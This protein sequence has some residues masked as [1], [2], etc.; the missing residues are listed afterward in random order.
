MTKIYEV[1]ATAICDV[2]IRIEA[3]SEDEA[4]KKVKADEGEVVDITFVRFDTRRSMFAK[5]VDDVVA[6]EDQ[7]D[8]R[9][10]WESVASVT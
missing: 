10:I 7:I 3:L 2:T 4:I 5:F 6:A 8:P 9:E 1:D